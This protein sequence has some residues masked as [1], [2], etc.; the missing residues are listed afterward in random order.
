MKNTAY[1]MNMFRLSVLILT[2]LAC[3][4][5]TQQPAMVT[6][7]PPE[8]LTGQGLIE[9]EPPGEPSFGWLV[10][11]PDSQFLAMAYNRWWMG[12][13]SSPSLFQIQVLEINKRTMSL[14]QESNQNYFYPVAWLSDNQIAYYSDD[15]PEGIWVIEVGTKDKEFLFRAGSNTILTRDGKDVAYEPLANNPSGQAL[16]I[17]S[18]EMD[19]PKNGRTYVL[20]NDKNLSVLLMQWSPN[21]NKI[22]YLLRNDLT[23]VSKMHILDIESGEQYPI[24]SEGYYG[25]ASWSPDGS[26]II[27]SY[28][29]ALAED[30]ELGLFLML[31]DG[32]C[33]TRV[34]DGGEIGITEPTWSPDGKWI[35]FGW[36]GGIYLLDVQEFLGAHSSESLLC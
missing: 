13:F 2:T 28:R 20:S 18:R 27:Y 11:S 16:V 21:S 15:G 9:I 24:G 4:Q 1:I 35:A 25:D 32:T 23:S 29:D 8:S 7:T 10:W 30:N 26:Y 34:L 14:I 6:A 31:S 5:L 36:N 19:L 12:K 17:V 3:G 33:P 22:I